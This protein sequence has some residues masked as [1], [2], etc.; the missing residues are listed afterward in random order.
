MLLKL[1]LILESVQ[2]RIYSFALRARF[3]GA[4]N[5]YI[6][7]SARFYG[8]RYITIGSNFTA[9]VGLRLEAIVQYQSLNYSPKIIIKDNV[10]LNDYVHIGATN[11]VEIGNNVLVASKVYISDHN[12]GVYSG[13]IQSSPDTS[14]AERYLTRDMSVIVGDN[15]WIGESVS[16][17][18]GVKIGYGSIIGAHSVVTKSVPA[19]TVVAGV[20]AKVIKRYDQN[21]RTW[22]AEIND[23]E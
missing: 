14:P 6:H 8:E 1:L 2:Q 16:I 17:L 7:R 23:E 22:N 3:K 15:V 21:S 11:Y 19:Y 10:T 9:L 5:I 20:P 18:P 13:S 12:H 4:V